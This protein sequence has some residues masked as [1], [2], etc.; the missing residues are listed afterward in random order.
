MLLI[1]IPLAL[2]VHNSL[3]HSLY[4]DIDGMCYQGPIFLFKTPV[5]F[6]KQMQSIL[7]LG[8]LNIRRH[9]PSCIDATCVALSEPQENYR[10]TVSINQ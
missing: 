7:S 2:L 9:M 1:L 8:Y 6:F 3:A 10:T 5:Q 4:D